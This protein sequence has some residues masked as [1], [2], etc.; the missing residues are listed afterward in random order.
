MVSNAAAVFST[1]GNGIHEFY[2][3]ERSKNIKISSDQHT[4]LPLLFPFPKK[5]KF[6]RSFYPDMVTIS[7]STSTPARPPVSRQKAQSS[8]SPFK[9]PQPT[10]TTTYIVQTG[11]PAQHVADLPLSTDLLSYY[12]ARLGKKNI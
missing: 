8:T 4:P 10:S 12:R 3:E 6:L 9:Q 7:A 2:F 5:C 1:V 11:P